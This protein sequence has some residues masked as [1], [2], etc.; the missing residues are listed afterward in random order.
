MLSNMQCSRR[1][2][3]CEFPLF[4]AENLREI[5][6]Q[7]NKIDITVPPRTLCIE[8]SAE[9]FILTARRPPS[10]EYLYDK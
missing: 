6:I 10:F 5:H 9:M 8:R 1:Y 4:Y 3:N 7:F 2:N